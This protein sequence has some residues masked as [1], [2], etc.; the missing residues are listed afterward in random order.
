MGNFCKPVAAE[1]ISTI[2]HPLLPSF[3]PS[4]LSFF[5][6]TDPSRITLNDIRLDR[7]AC[8]FQQ[9]NEPTFGYGVGT[10]TAKLFCCTFNL[11]VDNFLV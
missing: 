7:V 1:V 10:N 4:F 9:R 3:L 6:S 2:F 5:L 11:N 8:R